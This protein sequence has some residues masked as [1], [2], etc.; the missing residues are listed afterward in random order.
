MGIRVFHCDDSEAFTRLVSFWLSEHDDIEYAGQ[1][2]TAEAALAALPEARPDVIL[3]DTLGRPG[4]DSLLLAMRAVAP[5]A[6]VIV[7]SGYVRLM[8]EGALGDEADAYLEKGDDEG[9]LLDAIRA[10][11]AA[12]LDVRLGCSAAPDVPPRSAPLRRPRRSARRHAA[13]HPEGLERDEPVL[14]ARRRGEDRGARA[15][16]SAR[17][18]R[19]FVDMRVLGHNPA[20]IIPAWRDF[21]ARHDGPVRGIGEPIWAGRGGAELVECQLHEALLNV[22]FDGA[23]EF[24]LLCPYD[25][26]ALDESVVHEA[27]AGHPHVNAQ[28][29]RAYRERGAAAGAV[30]VAAAR[31]RPRTRGVLGFELDTLA[32]VRRADRGVRRRTSSTRARR[33]SCW[34]SRSG[35]QQHPARRRAR[36]PAH[37]A[38]RRHA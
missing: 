16:R 26:S 38:R 15:T 34:P 10:V 14:V 25:T 3:L 4:D 2:H 6:K 20:R 17:A 24:S 27:C 22:A 23:D 12:H 36:D 19:T 11:V 35:R 30:R 13:V 37:L 29:S 1:A 18:T 33:T 7:Y 9:P 8:Q 5:G 28:P 31:R 21:R 32:E